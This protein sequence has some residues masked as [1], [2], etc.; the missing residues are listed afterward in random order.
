MCHMITRTVREVTEMVSCIRTQVTVSKHGGVVKE[1]LYVQYLLV[2]SV[3][4]HN[5]IV[6]ACASMTELQ[7]ASRVINTTYAGK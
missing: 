2:S 5:C 1:P 7:L 6:Q 3:Y 4:H